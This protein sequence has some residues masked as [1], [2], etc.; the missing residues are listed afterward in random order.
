MGTADPSCPPLSAEATR[1]ARPSKSHYT[2][3]GKRYLLPALRAAFALAEP[4]ELAHAL[5]VAFEIANGGDGHRCTYVN[6]QHTF[7]S[8]T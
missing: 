3:P 5:E 7:D 6:G 4:L 8:L 1:A 2:W